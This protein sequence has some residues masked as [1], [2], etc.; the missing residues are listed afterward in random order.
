MDAAPQNGHRI[1]EIAENDLFKLITRGLTAVGLPV[2][3]YLG[4]TI[5]ADVATLKTQVAVI[6]S[7]LDTAT[8]DRWTA[9][10][11]AAYAEYSNLRF[12]AIEHRI[13]Q[14]ERRTGSPND[15]TRP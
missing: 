12:Q 3:L 14:L 8:A 5:L 13:E 9:T 2:F 15:G 1:Q 7:K 10:M 11:H 6:S 4:A